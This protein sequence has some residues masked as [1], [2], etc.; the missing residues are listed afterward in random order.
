MVRKRGCPAVEFFIVLGDEVLAKQRH[1]FQAFTQWGQMNIDHVDP[2][3]QIFAE[4]A[5]SNLFR[6]IAVGGEDEADA[7]L[8][9]FLAANTG[10]LAVLENV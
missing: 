1:I 10:K 6:Q 3:K 5:Q 2:V 7:D 8:L 9:I 4:I